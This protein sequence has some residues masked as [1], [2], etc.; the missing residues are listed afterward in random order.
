MS[1]KEWSEDNAFFSLLSF[2]EGQKRV[3]SRAAGP[4]EGERYALSKFR[5]VT[6]KL[7]LENNKISS[8]TADCEKLKAICSRRGIIKANT[9]FFH[10]TVCSSVCVDG[11]PHI[12]GERG[13]WKVT[14]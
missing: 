5:P 12:S 11:P 3:E 14:T 6:M 1:P 7:A 2:I 4:W 8:I 13:L 10:S 9:V